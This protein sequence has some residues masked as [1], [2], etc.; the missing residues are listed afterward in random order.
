MTSALGLDRHI[1]LLPAGYETA[2]GGAANE[3]VPR[4]LL[5][6]ILIA[7]ALAPMPRLLILDEAQAFLDQG[8]DV[9]LREVLLDLKFKSTII[10]VTNRPEYIAISDRIF[11][12]A[13]GT[14]TLRAHDNETVK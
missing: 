10:L 5:Q 12:M 8:T 1:S 13:P 2:L 3:A 11:D 7:R 9:K 14:I 6:G 4:G